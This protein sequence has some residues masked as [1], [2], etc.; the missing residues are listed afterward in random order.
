M[1]IKINQPDQEGIG[2]ILLQ[3]PMLMK[4]YLGQMP[5]EGFF[6]TQDIG[7]LDEDGYLYIL[8][9]RQNLIIS[10]GKISTPKKSRKFF[11]LTQM[12]RNAL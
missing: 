1:Q 11:L 2:E 9:C 6:N 8:H 5:L 3:G 10:G 7:Y 4:G 12:Y